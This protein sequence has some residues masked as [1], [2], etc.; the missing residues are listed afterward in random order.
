[1]PENSNNLKYGFFLSC[2]SR[3][4]HG[5]STAHD[6]VWPGSYR[7]A[8]ANYLAESGQKVVFQEQ[9]LQAGSSTLG[10]LDKYIARECKAVIQLLG[11][12]AGAYPKSDELTE[13]LSSHP[14]LLANQPRLREELAGANF[15]SLSYTQWEAVLAIHYAITLLLYAIDENAPRVPAFNPDPAQM[16]S[17]HQHRTRMAGFVSRHPTPVHSVDE[18]LLKISQELMREGLTIGALK[19]KVQNLP[20]KLGSLFKGRA[21]FLEKIAASLEKSATAITTASHAI[22]GAGGIGKTQAAVE[23]AWQNMDRYDAM[24]F[25]VAETPEGVDEQL[26]NLAGV[27]GVASEDA[28]DDHRMNSVLDWLARNPRWLLIVDNVDTKEARKR[29]QE[30]LARLSH[31]HVLMTSRI[32]VWIGQDVEALPLDLLELDDAVEFLLDDTNS[33]RRHAADDAVVARQV[34]KA[35]GRLSLGLAQARSFVSVELETYRYY[36]DRYRAND[37]SVIGWFDAE[38]CGYPRSTAVAWK[39]SVDRLSPPARFLLEILSWFGPE[40]IPRS[41]FSEVPDDL[42][43]RIPGCKKLLVELHGL[44]LV[45][46]DRERPTFWM[47]RL[48]QDSTRRR[49]LQESGR[50]TPEALLAAVDWLTYILSEDPRLI[51]NRER[52]TPLLSHAITVADFANERD[53]F[54]GLL[55]SECSLIALNLELATADELVRRIYNYRATKPSEDET[56]KFVSAFNLALFLTFK[57]QFAA[58]EEY[59]RMA[60]EGFK[61][62]LG[63]NS[64]EALRCLGQLALIMQGMNR[65]EDAERFARSSLEGF[66]NNF[67]AIDEH[68]LN[69]AS[70][71]GLVLQANGKLDEAEALFRRALAGQDRF[72]NHPDT[73]TTVCNLASCLQAKGDLKEAEAL[74][75]RGFKSRTPVLGLTHRDTLLSLKQLAGLTLA[76]GKI[77]DSEPLYRQA[78]EGF[79]RTVGPAH[80]YRISTATELASLLRAKGDIAESESLLLCIG[81]PLAAG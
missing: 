64:S 80:R 8:I 57:D 69:G 35:L 49:Q 20:H 68:L 44:S 36:L 45:E 79:D 12:A 23:Y 26:R 9:F 71:L 59:S 39:T 46:V 52:F 72:P 18:L 81:V 63:P 65:P 22:Y 51:V 29:V 78:L 75:R 16:E 53:F 11:K 42:A 70:V 56:A 41:L 21:S 4:L 27:L 34:A 10:K 67:D 7:T 2:V 77:E 54:A 50:S 28:N 33:N 47:H 73:L 5:D 38:A 15:S 17:Q 19:R 31:G 62:V 74:S 66:E 3:E 61:V 6:P 76:Q 30:R 24:L 14:N 60:L 55:Y 58:A 43:E 1:M 37:D 13:F 32:P 48:I 40:E 25:L